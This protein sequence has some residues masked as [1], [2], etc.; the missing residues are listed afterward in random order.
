MSDR[1]A[2]MNAGRIVQVAA[3][4]AMYEAPADMFVAG[5][6]GNPPIAFLEAEAAGGAARLRNGQSVAWA[7]EGPVVLG[8]RPE[9]F[10]PQHGTGLAGTVAMMETHGREDL[11]QVDL[12]GG[13]QLRA[14][15]PAGSGIRA[16]DRVDWGVAAEKLLAFRPDGSRA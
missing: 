13:G 5:F 16:G 8:V 2:I 12:G 11:F 7:G 15:L 1:I 10:G 6:L 3:P 9:H 4:A 14:I